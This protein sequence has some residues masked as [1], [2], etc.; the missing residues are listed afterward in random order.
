M[1][2]KHEENLWGSIT[3]HGHTPEWGSHAA[4]GSELWD[5]PSV[6]SATPVTLKEKVK[7]WFYPKKFFLYSHIYKHLLPKISEGEVVRILDIGCGTGAS[8]IDLKRLFGT[9]A[10]LFGLE[11]V[12]LQV[13]IAYRRLRSENVLAD[14][15]WYDGS[16]FPFVDESF[17]AIYSSDVLG[18]VVD[19]PTWLDEI[20]RVLKPDGV[21]A[22]FSESKLGKHAFVRNYL[23]K[24][25]LNVDPHAEFH[26]S[27][28]SKSELKNLFDT[29]GFEI[30]DMRTLFWASFLVHPDEFYEKF[31]AQK[32]FIVLKA[33]NKL[34]Y[35]I[36][37]KLHPFS[38]AC[39]ELYGLI[40]TLI[41]GKYVESQG[42]VILGKKK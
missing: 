3:E 11:V 36:K 38:T 34:L 8:V 35:T 10:D 7:L 28:Y 24:R 6:F 13:D 2:H 39:A 32:K 23:F 29:H 27:L 14:V 26:I 37:K 12:N 41:F 30:E 20:H 18:H 15:Q 42:Y 31:Q 16:T 21:I 25:G 19:V 5:T 33:I 40:E 1:T 9:K 4:D 17:D 22:I